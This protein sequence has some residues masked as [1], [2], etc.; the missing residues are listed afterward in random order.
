MVSLPFELAIIGRRVGLAT[1]DARPLDVEARLCL[2]SVMLL[3][4]DSCFSACSAALYDVA[5]GRV[6]ASACDV[7]ERGH[8]EALGPMVQRLFDDV[9]LSPDQ[10]TRIAVTRGPGT[11]TGL[12]IGLS[13][14][15]GMA[16]ALSIPL[17]GIDSL[18]AT[19]IPHLGGSKPFAISLPA[20]GTGLFYWALFDGLD[21]KAVTP[22][23]L[24]SREDIAR[25]ADNVLAATGPVAKDFA[26]YAAS[27]P[28]A[29]TPV[30]PLYLRL[31]DAKPSVLPDASRAHTRLA[32]AADI[33]LM[34]ALHRE[35]FAR[36][37]TVEE[38]SSMLSTSGS[39]GLLVELG[40]VAYGFVQ[41]QAVQGEVE[42]NTI[43]VSP[44]YRRQHF[45]QDL[46]QG[47][48]QHLKTIGTSKVFLEV[49]A[50]N[51]AARALYARFGFQVSGQRNAYYAD[52]QDAVTM[53][54]DLRG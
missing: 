15:K 24:S 37:W 46:M 16:L 36:G 7:M 30:E 53:V 42:I 29:G 2:S 32:L 21:A 25:V 33:P 6:V 10:L 12:R 19:A 47:L 9:G 3:V 54:K 8:A 39:A 18:T 20:G 14:A 4:I 40:G 52:G 43:C 38:L 27:L 1:W 50:K 13:F 5:A 49:A 26:A 48:L 51:E 41:F 28:V 35:S 17:L 31:P 23:A 45:A 22:P 44:N 11:F 34:A